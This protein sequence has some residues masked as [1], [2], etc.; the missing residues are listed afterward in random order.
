MKTRTAI[1]RGEEAIAVEPRLAFA[2]TGRKRPL[3]RAA[4]FQ[5]RVGKAADVEIASC[6]QAAEFVEDGFGVGEFEQR[7]S[8]RR[9]QPRFERARNPLAID[10][11]A[12]ASPGAGTAAR[13]RE[14]RRSELVTVPSFSLQLVAGS[15]T[16]A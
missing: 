7:R 2:G 11:S 15:S 3:L 9:C 4:A 12:R 10:Q 16:S 13:T 5:Q 6:G 14:M 1:G 8:A